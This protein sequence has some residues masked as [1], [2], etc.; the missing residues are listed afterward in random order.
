MMMRIKHVDRLIA[1]SVVGAILIVWLVLVGFDALN[2][3]VRQLERVGDHGY[4]VGDALSFIALTLPRRMYQHFGSASLIGGLLGL[5]GLA[6][7]G[8]L[9]ALRAAGMSKFRIV[10]SVV[11]VT[12][13]LSLLVMLMGETLGPAGDQ[14]ANALWVRSGSGHLSLTRGSGLW[15]RDGDQVINARSALAVQHANRPSTVRLVDVREFSFGADGQLDR[16]LRAGDATRDDG[17]WTL[18]QVRVSHVDD[19]GVEASE[20]ASMPW[21]THLDPQV[22]KQSLVHPEYLSIPDLH[23]NMR[24]LAAN[25]LDPAPYANAFWGHVLFPFS[26]LALVFCAM[27]FAFGSVRSGGLG[28]RVFIGILLAIG[29]YFLQRV[30]TNMG[31]VYGVSALLANLLPPLLLVILAGAY[32]RRQHD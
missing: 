26:V 11:M 1:T 12:G 10:L 8:E 22:L 30:I 13:A 25:G 15:V 27:P 29:W 23:R 19:A 4:T 18:H 21:S 7:S 24:Y 32:F 6:A 3:L 28:R 5:G 14:R 31:M 16:F 9:T 20:Q 17:K 2:Q